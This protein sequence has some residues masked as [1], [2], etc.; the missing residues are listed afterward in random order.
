MLE[1]VRGLSLYLNFAATGTRARHTYHHAGMVSHVVAPDSRDQ[2]P[3]NNLAWVA[4]RRKV[5]DN[6][7]HTVPAARPL[8][9]RSLAAAQHKVRDT[10]VHTEQAAKP[11]DG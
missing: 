8:V 3:S 7:G 6:R 1:E 11:A 4:A 9:E 5:W 2:P 10:R